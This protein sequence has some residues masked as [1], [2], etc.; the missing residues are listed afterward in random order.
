MSKSVQ[1]FLFTAPVGVKFTTTAAH[2]H[3]K[4]RVGIGGYEIEM[5]GLGAE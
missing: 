3:M 2:Y 1:N 5:L 4:A